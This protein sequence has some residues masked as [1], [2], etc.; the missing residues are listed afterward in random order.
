MWDL[1]T[2]DLD[3]RYGR[4]ICG[5]IKEYKGKIWTVRTDDK[6]NPNP[7]NDRWVVEQTLR[8]MKKY[9]MFITYNGTLFDWRFLSTRFYLNKMHKM[10]WNKFMRYHRDVLYYARSKFRV[11]GRAQK[12]IHEDLFGIS[13]KT[14][15]T[16]E[17]KDAIMRGDKKA[18]D[19]EVKHCKIDVK[20]LEDI[21]SAFL[22]YL[23]EAIKRRSI[24]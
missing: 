14:F 12:R 7:F 4:I 16:P 24:P 10:G 3:A 6:R 13:S 19:W 17:L 15:R 20:E 18:I 2:T 5:C 23:S 21:Y 11:R 1:E 8:E 22:P 9:D